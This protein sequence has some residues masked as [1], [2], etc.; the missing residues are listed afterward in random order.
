ML[1]ARPGVDTIVDFQVGQ[2]RLRLAGG[3]SPEQLTFTSSGSHTLIR[4]GNSTVAILQNMQP[5]SLNLSTLFDPPGNSAA[6]TG[7]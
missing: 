7:L 1:G 2:D 5:S 6:A 4:N 3:L